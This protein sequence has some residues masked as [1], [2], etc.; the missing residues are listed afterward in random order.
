MRWMARVAAV[1]I[2]RS[3]ACILRPCNQMQQLR[4]ISVGPWRV[5]VI[6]LSVCK[7]HMGDSPSLISLI[8]RTAQD[9]QPFNAWIINHGS[10]YL[11][12]LCANAAESTQM[13][14]N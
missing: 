2:S 1:V 10:R 3:L 7:L 8:Q 14:R 4:V 9:M 11:Q 5:C 13:I 6:A 12:K